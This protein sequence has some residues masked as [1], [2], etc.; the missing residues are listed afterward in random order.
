MLDNTHL[1]LRLVE[2]LQ[3]LTIKDCQNYMSKLDIISTVTKVAD[4]RSAWKDSYSNRRDFLNAKM[5]GCSIG[6]VQ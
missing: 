5:A 4:L 6:R 3:L 2:D 1:E